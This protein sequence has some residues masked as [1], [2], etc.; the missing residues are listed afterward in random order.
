MAKIEVQFTNRSFL[1]TYMILTN[2]RDIVTGKFWTARSTPPNW[3]GA[4][5]GHDECIFSYRWRYNNSVDYLWIRCCARP[6]LPH[7]I[8]L[9]MHAVKTWR[10]PSILIKFI[11]CFFLFLY[12]HSII[13]IMSRLEICSKLYKS[14]KIETTS[15]LKR[16]KL[17]KHIRCFEKNIY[18]DASVSPSQTRDC[19]DVLNSQILLCT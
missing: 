8:I 16:R 14:R 18:E 1:F 17:C 10:T 15:N 13:F 9:Y 4:A 2:Q 11:A 7:V 6:Y 5:Y 3:I 12:I 19:V